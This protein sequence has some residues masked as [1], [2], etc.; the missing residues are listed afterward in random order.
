MKIQKAIDLIWKIVEEG[1]HG[2]GEEE[3][4]W[5]NKVIIITAAMSWE[6]LMDGSNILGALYEPLHTKPEG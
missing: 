4:R 5:D 6:P 3:Q 2:A 1:V